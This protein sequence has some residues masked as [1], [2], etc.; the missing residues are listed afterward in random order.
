M[1]QRPFLTSLN[2]N[3]KRFASKCYARVLNFVCRLN[4][5]YWLLMAIRF[6]AV[7]Q[8]WQ[9][10][11]LCLIRIR[12]RTLLTSILFDGDEEE[13]LMENRSSLFTLHEEED[14]VS[15]QLFL[16]PSWW[17]CNVKGLDIAA[18][19]RRS[20]TFRVSLAMC[21]RWDVPVCTVYRYVTPGRF[22]SPLWTWCT[23]V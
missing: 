7:H 22:P 11:C 23:T 2:V 13:V 4:P 9:M 10:D 19:S 14:L 20:E 12:M 21:L 16:L 3:I 1:S 18:V 15:E 5:A 8:M 17:S 6:T